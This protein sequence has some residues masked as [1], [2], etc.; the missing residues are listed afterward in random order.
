[1][2]ALRGMRRKIRVSAALF[3]LGAGMR[4]R[5]TLFVCAWIL[6]FV[7][8][9]GRALRSP[10]CVGIRFS[11]RH[12]S[13]FIHDNMDLLTLHEIFVELPYDVATDDPLVIVDIGANIG[14]S[15]LFFH[16][17]HPNATIYAYE[18]NPE[19]VPRL[20][21]NTK[22]IREIHVIGSA[23]AAEDGTVVF[24]PNKTHHSSSLA[25]REGA[26][27]PVTV[28]AVALDSVIEAAGGS[29]D[30]LKFD[31]E[32]AEQDVFAHA[33]RT[34]RI[35]HLI[36]EVHFDLMT[37]GEKEFISLFPAHD[38]RLHPLR[39]QR[40]VADIRRPSAFYGNGV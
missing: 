37:I 32:G 39:H 8:G 33:Q 14:C 28:P 7:A 16:L 24:Y 34:D 20:F 11:G 31:I 13:Y 6:P 5:M 29:V 4:D 40:F 22:D 30:L 1:M 12:A 36:G 27:D 21:R 38:V 17:R 9:T 26:G 3:S 15:T 19:I 35:A 18:A 10:I 25:W 23:V 2:H